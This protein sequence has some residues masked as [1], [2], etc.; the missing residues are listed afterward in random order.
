VVHLTANGAARADVAVGEAVEFTAVVEV[1]PG[2]GTIVAAEWDFEGNGDFP[3][4]EPFTNEDVSYTSTNITR[5]FAFASPGTYFPAVRVTAQRLG[6]ADN[7]HG[8][9]LNLGRVRVVVA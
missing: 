4:T 5:D 2:T 3:I 9:I 7:P 1:P 8:R 6:Q